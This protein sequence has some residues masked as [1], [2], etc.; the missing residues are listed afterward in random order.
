L[1]L[2]QHWS[3]KWLTFHSDFNFPIDGSPFFASAESFQ[4]PIK[5]FSV[6]FGELKPIEKVKRFRLREITTVMQLSCNCRQILHADLVVTRLFFKNFAAF[7]LSQ[8]PS[9]GILANG[10]KNSAGCF[11]TT[12]WR[13]VLPWLFFFWSSYITIVTGNA[14]KH[15]STICRKR[16]AS[17]DD[18][19]SVP[20]Q[21]RIATNRRRFDDFPL[22]LGAADKRKKSRIRIHAVCFLDCCLVLC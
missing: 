19:Q 7:I 6:F 15:P 8:L 22:A 13:L 16:L 11:R 21:Q 1:Q 10:D 4:E 9:F 5:P 17:G 12:E 2:A 14:V 18:V 20:I 3:V